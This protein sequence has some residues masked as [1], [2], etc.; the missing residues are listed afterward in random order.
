MI[1]VY[2]TIFD[3]N[4]LIIFY[5]DLFFRARCTLNHY[6]QVSVCRQLVWMVSPRDNFEIAGNQVVQNG[7]DLKN[8]YQLTTVKIFDIKTKFI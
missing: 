3:T 6:R 1:S 4:S 7:I 8:S 2:K 5:S